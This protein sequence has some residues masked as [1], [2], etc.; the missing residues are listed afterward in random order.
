[1][2]SLFK[3]LVVIGICVGS[4]WSVADQE[5]KLRVAGGLGSTGYVW[6]K[7]SRE[8]VS[9]LRL[10]GDFERGKVA[11][12][13]CRGCHKADGSGRTDGK[14]PRLTGQHAAVVIKQ[15]TDTRSGLRTNP[16]M[17]PFAESHAVTDQ[18]VADI[19][20]YLAQVQTDLPNGQGPGTQVQRGKKVYETNRCARCH[21]Q[22]GE[23]NAGN[24]YPVVAF[25]HYEYA[26]REM[27]HIKDGTRSNGHPEMAQV[28][29]KLSTAD[30]QALADYLSRLPD[31]RM[32]IKPA[33]PQ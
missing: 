33:E 23:G 21:G 32:V 19:A 8:Q 6:N 27:Q 18:E 26:L 7:L 15:V 17:A 16:K 14:Y 30:I 31:Y 5:D 1:M 25:Q 11:F 10:Q 13:A 4:A 20:Q 28:M 9:I 12:R 3:T 24:V 22:R 2:M 29:R